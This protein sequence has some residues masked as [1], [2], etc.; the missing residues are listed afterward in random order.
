VAM[1]SIL[2]LM[3]VVQLGFDS[4]A[5]DRLLDT[6]ET[7]DGVNKNALETNI[8][9][10][11]TLWAGAQYLGRS[12]VSG[13]AVFSLL[14]ATGKPCSLSD[15]QTAARKLELHTSAVV[16]KRNRP[17]SLASPAIIRLKPRSEQDIGHFI[18]LLS[19]TRNRILYLDVPKA[20]EFIPDEQ[21]WELWD[22]TAL[23]VATDAELL[24]STS[25]SQ[26]LIVGVFSAC[27]LMLGC[28]VVA[29]VMK[30]SPL[31]SY[32]PIRERLAS[33]STFN[34]TLRLFACGCVIIIAY[35]GIKQVGS[36][37]QVVP[38]R[39]ALEVV[40]RLWEGTVPKG[41]ASTTNRAN[42]RFELINRS[43][44]EVK[45][46]SVQSSCG[47]ASPVLSASI[48]P[49]NGRVYIDVGVRLATGGQS[50]FKIVVVVD[51]QLRE[52]LLLEGVLSGT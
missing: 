52:S 38:E 15:L 26:L 51:E 20:P 16:W 13:D 42:A 21:L 23:H 18:L 41:W 46:L 10:Q 14:P 3:A 29:F 30:G 44:Q 7:T 5:K 22:G 19:H 2:M 34:W 43:D 25:W 11:L 28:F 45:I 37:S 31:L 40:P 8:C 17:I 48:I 39:P 32:G 49:P 6:P 24:P 12:D 50:R 27:C 47:C 33:R 1:H 36:R 35:V 4:S 9:G